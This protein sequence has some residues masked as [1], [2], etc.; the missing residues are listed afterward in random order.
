MKLR[1]QNISKFTVKN[2]NLD[3]RHGEI[4][5]LLGASGSGKTTLLRI[6]SGVETPDSGS[7][8]IDETTLVN[9][10]INVPPEK[11][12]VG[13]VF[14]NFCL[15]PHLR[16]DQNITFGLRGQSK[17]Q[18][19]NRLAELISFSDLHGLEK[20]YP[21]QLSGGQQQRVALARALANSP[22]IILLDEPFSNLDNHLRSNLRD[23]MRTFLKK[24][25]ETAVFVTH[26]SQDAL[27]LSD[28]IAILNNG[29]I[30]QIDTPSA[31]YNN[32]CSEYVAN[33]F[34]PTNIVEARA[35]DGGF[36]TELGTVPNPHNHEIGSKGRICIRPHWCYLHDDKATFSGSVISATYHGDRQE[37]KIKTKVGTFTIHL[38]HHDKISIG[39][40][41]SVAIDAPQLN[42]F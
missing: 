24:N 31:I 30:E 32:P 6:I 11:R 42:L 5:T 26:D 2:L 9:D 20:R 21:H 14:Q 3:I 22:S 28:R 39:D 10:A 33:Y 37:A 25:N 29:I 12:A 19:K 18:K 41:I 17:T 40:K 1:L 7:V 38:N 16:V 15:F 35:V 34:G 13:M 4:L 36:A 8:T 27:V 23:E